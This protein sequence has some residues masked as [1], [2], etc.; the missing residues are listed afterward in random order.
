MQQDLDDLLPRIASGDPTAFA[1]WLAGAE[2]PV[3]LS[4]RGLARWV[5]VEAVLQ[6]TLLRVW[7]VAPRLEPDGR[8]NG[9]LRFAIRAA[10]NLAISEIRRRK[11]P[12][13]DPAV[14]ERAIEEA[15]VAASPP[16][17]DPL[18]RAATMDCLEALPPK[19]RTVIMVR[20]SSGGAADDADLARGLSMRTNTFLQ[21][22]TRA[23]NALR[24]CLE[25]KGIDVGARP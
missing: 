22:F 3:R 18:L 5:D 15:S 24:T 10:H 11:T 19:A 21:S 12:G 13:V 20:I 7:Q 23:R 8:P 16:P 9:L 25:N 17:H 2:R 4:L 1:R 14:L 6:E